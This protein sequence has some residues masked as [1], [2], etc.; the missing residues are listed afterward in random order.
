MTSERPPNL[1]V[2][3]RVYSV[4]FQV[5]NLVKLASPLPLPLQSIQVHTWH[6]RSSF[7]LTEYRQFPFSKRRL[8][9]AEWWGGGRGGGGE[10][11]TRRET[12][13]N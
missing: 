7:Y 1:L 6:I 5:V 2:E 12:E 11:E 10:R 3:T 9:E 4:L 13:E 8:E